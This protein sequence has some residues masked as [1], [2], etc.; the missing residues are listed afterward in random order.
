ML[1]GEWFYS[2]AVSVNRTINELQL[3]DISPI[4]AYKALGVKDDGY[5][6]LKEHNL[7]LAIMTEFQAVLLKKLS[8]LLCMDSTHKTNE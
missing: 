6:M 3:E 8:N 1:K 2:D 7:L 5:P 4:V